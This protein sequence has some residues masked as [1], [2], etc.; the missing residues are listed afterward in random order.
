MLSLAWKAGKHLAI[1]LKRL[2]RRTAVA[3]GAEGLGE[4]RR[5]DRLWKACAIVIP[6]GLFACWAVPQ[7]TLV[8]SPSVDAWAV[9]PSPGPIAKGDLVMFK[10]SHPLA[11]SE[12]VNVTKLALCMPGERISLIERP[13]TI[14]PDHME[15]WYYC[16]GVLL[17][18]TKPYGQRGQKLEYWRPDNGRIKPG[19]IYVGSSHP[20]GFDSRYYGPV[21][22]AR[23]AR[24]EK[25]L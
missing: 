21:A 15:G 9:R 7:V 16:E 1:G 2:P 20:S 23:L 4:P 18:V 11:G 19:T 6:L 14:I 17:G 5:P 13:S 8:M 24:V 10:L 22:I 25:V 12:P 3:L